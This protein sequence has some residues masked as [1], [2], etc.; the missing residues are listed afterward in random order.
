MIVITGAT[1]ALNGATLK[2][3]LRHVPATEIAASVRDLRAATHLED[4]G[5]EVRQGSYQD[6]DQLRESFRGA[7]QVLLVSP[8][9]P[10]ADAVALVEVGVE[11]ALAAGAQRILY[12]SHQAA[13]SSNPFHPGRDHAAVE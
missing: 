12:T 4:L 10:H 9:D 13:H 1:G 5:I 11:A 6:A 7:D 3:L 8:S 2:H